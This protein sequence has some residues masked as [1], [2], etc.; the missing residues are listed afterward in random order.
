MEEQKSLPENKEPS[1]SEN[2]P[3]KP[4]VL[5]KKKPTPIPPEVLA[6]MPPEAKKMVERFMM[7]SVSMQGIRTP[8]R[9]PILKKIDGE[10]IHKVLDIAK[11]DDE[12]NFQNQIS[13][14]R[15]GAFYVVLFVGLFVFVTVYVGTADKELYKE[16]LKFLLI[17]LG[18][19]GS[20]YGLKTYLNKK[21]SEE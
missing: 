2:L 11:A 21:D 8:P 3:E 4:E 10:H 16:L 18:G 13:A 20:G 1:T 17:Y 9:N 14:R 15:Y 19:L 12:R 5:E 6:G 7:Q